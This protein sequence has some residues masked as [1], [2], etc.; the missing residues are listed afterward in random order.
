MCVG[1]RKGA[2]ERLDPQQFASFVVIAICILSDPEEGR[3]Y[4]T[5]ICREVASFR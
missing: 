4:W 3:V 5:K 1:G 2:G